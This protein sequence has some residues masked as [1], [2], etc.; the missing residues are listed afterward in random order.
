M[1]MSMVISMGMIN[2]IIAILLS[3][4]LYENM[5]ISEINHSKF[6]KSMHAMPIAV[7]FAFLSLFLMSKMIYIL[8]CAGT[9]LL[10][11]KSTEK[12]RDQY[13]TTQSFYKIYKYLQIQLETGA[14][15]EDIFKSL[16]RVVAYPKFRKKLFQFSVIISQSHDVQMGLDYLKSELKDQEGKLF[17]NIT[18]NLASAGGEQETFSRLNHLLFQ[19][20]LSNIRETTKKIKRMY[21]YSVILFT[22]LVSIMLMMPIID[23]MLKSTQM[24]FN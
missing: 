6:L 18:E 11:Y 5:Q 4:I 7:T 3:L 8:L 15:A 21:L 1:V 13:M 19:K 23:Q 20:Y 16:Y 24:I 12:Q 2:I 17:I 22:I 14:R 9:T 10:I